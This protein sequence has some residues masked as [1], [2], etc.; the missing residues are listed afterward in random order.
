M[1]IESF[2]CY[3]SCFMKLTHILQN[4]AQVFKLQDLN[5][6]QIKKFNRKFAGR[7]FI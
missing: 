6:N 5:E 2:S 1:N 7:N 4:N 3:S